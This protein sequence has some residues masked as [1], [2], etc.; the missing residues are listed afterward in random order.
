MDR[1]SVRDRSSLREW[2]SQGL[3]ELAEALKG[4]R[5]YS[6]KLAAAGLSPEDLGDVAALSRFPFTTK[7]ELQEDQAAHPPYGSNLSFPL[8]QYSRLHQTSGTMG[9]PIRWLDTVESWRWFVGCWD[10]IF[11]AAGVDPADRFLVPSTFGPFIGF[12][13]AFEA[14]VG[15]GNLCIAGGGMTS[16]IRLRW[17]LDHAVTALSVTPTYALRL[18]EVAAEEGIDLRSSAVRLLI[19][20]G[21]P[22]GNIPEVKR[23][24]ESGWG[25][26]CFDHWGMT[27]VGPLGFEPADRPGAIHINELECFAEVVD[28]DSGECLQGPGRGELV[29]TTFARTGSPLIRYRTGDLV[30]LAAHDSEGAA[31]EPRTG[32]PF[33]RLEGGILGRVDQMV[34]IRGNNV[35]P[36]AID[37][38]VRCFDSIREYRSEIVQTSSGDH[39]RLKL[40]LVEE[41][42]VEAADIAER[43]VRKVQ[44]V[45]FFRPEVLIVPAATLPRFEFKAQRFVRVRDGEDE[46]EPDAC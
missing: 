43:V 37:A 32:F 6:D 28:P 17:I 27:E 26:R 7:V 31:V 46:F 29:V 41:P 36:G 35:Y 1:Q 5:F 9:Q 25:A 38:V 45:L 12:W 22:G 11:A 44:E 10:M 30:D 19:V 23:R 4:N 39:L 2:Q 15:H 33:I 20:A 34:S 8:E 42:G 18:L 13:G 16:S 24:I 14:A 3:R 40:E 21:E